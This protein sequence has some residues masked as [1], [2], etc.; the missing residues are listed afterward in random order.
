MATDYEELTLPLSD[1]EV[2]EAIIEEVEE[3]YFPDDSK[4]Y[5]GTNK[6]RCPCHRR[7]R[8]EE[9]EKDGKKKRKHCN[10]CAIKVILPCAI[11]AHLLDN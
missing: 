3:I 7:R 9:K 11:T 1:E 2:A 10:S 5:Y 6:C 8:Q 4:D